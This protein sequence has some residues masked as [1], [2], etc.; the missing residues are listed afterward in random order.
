L[1]A[2][3]VND[4][5]TQTLSIP[6]NARLQWMRGGAAPEIE[7]VTFE[8]STNGGGSWSPLG[9]GTRI[10]GGWERTGLSLS[11]FGQI[12][13]RGRT[14]G[15]VF[16]GSSG[17]VEQI[18]P[19]DFLTQAPT[20]NAPV[21]GAQTPSPV[22]IAFTLPEAAQP[23]SVTL[24]FDD[25]ITPRVLVLAASQASA[26][27][28]AFSFD[29]AAPTTA[30]QI[31]SGP[32]LPEGIYAVT[33]SYQDAPGNAPASSA[34][35]TNVRI[36]ASPLRL[37]K[38]QQLGDADAS[39]LGDIEADGL[40]HLAEYGLVLSPLVPNRPP[41]VARFVYAEGARLRMTLT[42]DPAR[43]DVTIEVQ[44]GSVPAGPWTTV[45]TSALGAPFTG[46]GYVG[47][48]SVGAG[49]KTVEVRDIV[50]MNAAAARYLRV[51]ITH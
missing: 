31:A 40:V 23:G 20:L 16:N 35:A 12:R 41:A 45:A 33:L 51:Q 27:A 44:A 26:G 18:A 29:I 42:R 43:N 49:L 50:N 24:T 7:Q 48:D 5:A 1:L 4:P 22:N 47:G 36:T 13:A 19:L 8:L 17:I 32:A 38:L 15:G 34:T 28:H 2:R 3:L 21:T 46:A 30:P 6:T 25:G 14:I 37:W 10:P 9:A 11:G 39:D